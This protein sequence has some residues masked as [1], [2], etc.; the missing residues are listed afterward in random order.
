MNRRLLHYEIVREIG[1]GGMGVVYLAHD[2]HLGRMVAVKVLPPDKVADPSRKRRFIQEA[3]AASALNHSNIITVHDVNCDDGV[4]FMVMEYVDG[5]TLDA[6]IPARGLRPSLALKYAIQIADALAAAHGAGI[7][8]RDLKPSNVMVTA[9]GRV[10]ILDFG[11]AK[12]VDAS[13]LSPEAPTF[14]ASAVTGEGVVMGTASYMSPEQAE[15]RKLDSR[16]DIFSFGSLLYEMVTGQQAFAGNSILSTLTKILHE[17]PKPTSELVPSIPPDLAK[18]ISRCLRKEPARRCQY[19]ADVKVALEDIQEES[20]SGPQAQA[21]RTAWRRRW[22]WMTIPPVLLAGGFL[23]WRQLRVSDVPEPP[24]AVPLTAYPGAET[25]PTISP[26]NNQVAFSWSGANQ[27]NNDIYVLLIGSAGLL[28][29]TTDPAADFSPSWSPDGRWIAF[30]RGPRPGRCEVRL[31]SPLG[32]PERMLAEVHVRQSD[33]TPPYLAWLPDGNSLIAVDSPGPHEPDALFVISAD[34]GEKRPLTLPERPALGDSNPAVSPDGRFVAFRRHPSSGLYVLALAEGATAAGTIRRLTPVAMSA[35]H[36]TWMPDGKTILF[37]AQGS[38]WKVD[39]SGAGAPTRVPF[40]GD[41]AL[42]P[43]LSRS[44]PDRPA[45]LVYVRASFDPNIWRVDTSAPGRPASSPPVAAIS[46]TLM[47]SN[48]QFSPDGRRVAFY[49]NRSGSGEIWI[50]DPDGSNAVQLTSMRAPFSGSPRWSP[51]GQTIAFDA[52]LDGQ[53]QVYVV[54]AAGGKPRRLTP[55]QGNNHVPSFSRD[56]RW[57]YF[58]SSRSGEVQIWK[59][60]VSGGDV[61]QVTGNGGFAAFESMDG[62]HVYYTQTPTSASA[63]WRVPTTGGAPVKVLDGVIQRAFAVLER[64]IYYI[65]AAAE[66]EPGPPVLGFAGRPSWTPGARLRFFDF[67]TRTS[68]V[69]SNL[70]ERISIGLTAS[71]DGRVILYSRIDSPM[72]D[73]MLVENFR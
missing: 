22:V 72:N 59:V 35:G 2:T 73:L 33:V 39:A 58:S 63:L 27:D 48:A 20:A 14:S 10:K 51:D 19:M 18:V 67:A 66:R 42:M 32:G 56:G 36:S 34:S 3:K 26:D 50:A 68:A 24:R 28:R 17:D 12:L 37:A 21:G 16:S 60:P 65:E 49:S 9:E 47:D 13:A 62:A 15:G 7:V 4:D 46:S 1:H 52:N 40:V 53:Y 6:R 8:H 54:A 43:V 11:L 23:A 31:V 41:G 38:L 45:R 5:E 29:L 44:Q 57:V 25:H 55:Q 71:P 30:V 64:G 61:V 69:V 70:G